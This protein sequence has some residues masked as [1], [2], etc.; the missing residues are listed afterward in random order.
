MQ[1]LPSLTQ[2]LSFVPLYMERVWGGR[3][4]ADQLGRD[5][6]GSSPIGE[7]WELVDREGEQSVVGD[8]PL[9]G[10]TLHELW[11][12][13]RKAIFGETASDSPRFPL[14]GK[15]LDARDTLSVQVH[16]PADIAPTLKGEPKTEMWYLLD[17]TPDASLYAG[18]RTGT[19]RQSFEKAISD[20]QVQSTLHMIPVKAG[21]TMFIPSGRCHAIGAGCLIIEIQQN[22][23]TTYRL[24][25]WDRMGLDGKPRE[26]H[27]KESLISTDF[28]DHEPA[29]AAE[30]DESLVSCE[31]FEVSRWQL[32]QPRAEQ[33]G[34]GTVFVVVSGTI[35]IGGKQFT[36]GDWFLLPACVQ[37]RTLSPVNGEACMLRCVLPAR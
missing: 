15:I 19:T 22:S 21:D 35:Q 32:T 36:T 1:S 29:L 20:G 18:F 6:P 26:L 28:A 2:P 16:P 5:L 33:D 30:I 34:I 14:L 10:T 13:H 7:S 37:D 8:G 25:D 3:Q 12:E 4:L 24:Y 11:T 27:V 9:K 31:H 23:D 17:A